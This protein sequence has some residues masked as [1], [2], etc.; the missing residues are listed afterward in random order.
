MAVADRIGGEALGRWICSGHD[1]H[2]G[3]E[4]EYVTWKWI[5]GWRI[6]HLTSFHKRRNPPNTLLPE[7]RACRVLSVEALKSHGFKQAGEPR[8]LRPAT[9]LPSRLRRKFMLES[10]SF[11]P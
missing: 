6:W 3:V 2:T 4:V 8:G 10:D 5:S 7:K 9:P 11:S 1:G